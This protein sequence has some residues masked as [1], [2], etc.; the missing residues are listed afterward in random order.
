MM[1]APRIFFTAV[2]PPFPPFH[3]AVS[4]P[5]EKSVFVVLKVTAR[6]LKKSEFQRIMMLQ[7]LVLTVDNRL[8][9]IGWSAH[10]IHLLLLCAVFYFQQLQKSMSA[11]ET[12]TQRDG[13]RQ[14]PSQP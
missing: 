1:H 2:S 11:I 14:P 12:V 3:R 5:Q 4:S 7:P 6:E 8:P 13:A 9:G 10:T